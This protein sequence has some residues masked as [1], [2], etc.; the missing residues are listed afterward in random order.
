MLIFQLIGAIRKEEWY[1]AFGFISLILLYIYMTTT[2]IWDE[3]YDSHIC[4]ENIF[5]VF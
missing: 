4:S 2:A 5:V 3:T 1:F